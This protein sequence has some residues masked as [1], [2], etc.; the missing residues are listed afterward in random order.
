MRKLLFPAAIAALFVTSSFT[1]LATQN[2][3]IGDGY[4]VKFHDKNAEGVFKDLKGD[5][6]FYEGNLAAAHMDVTIAVSSINTGNGL[7]NKH[8]RGEQWFDA[9]KYPTIHFVS[10]AIT[11]SKEGYEAQGMLE[12]HGVKKAV[13][14]PFTFQNEGTTGTFRGKFQ[15][16]RAD[17]NL[18]KTK[19]NETDITELDITVPVT[20]K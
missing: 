20:S 2:W 9:E 7:K 19:G 16:N 11:K 3:A 12:L 4:A 8:A 15:V 14:I 10:T 18:G 6:V 13:T 5:V 17:Y 1:F